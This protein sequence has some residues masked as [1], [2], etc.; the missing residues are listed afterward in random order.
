MRELSFRAWNE[1]KNEFTYWNFNELPIDWDASQG[2]TDENN[3][4]I[5]IQTSCVLEESQEFT[6]RRDEK[7]VSIYELDIIKFA[8]DDDASR[9]GT[10]E[11]DETLTSYMVVSK[12]SSPICLGFAKDVIII[13]NTIQNPDIIK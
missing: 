3:G 9:I 12:K 6:G 13:G 1:D 2:I 10:V 4:S 11:Y 8:A 7:G 5:D